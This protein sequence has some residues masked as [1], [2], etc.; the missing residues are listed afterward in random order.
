VDIAFCPDPSS[1]YGPR[2]QTNIE[3]GPLSEPLC[4]ASRPGHF[5][6][7]AT[8]VAKLFNLT[9][10]HVAIFGQKDFQQ[11][12][13]IRQM[14]VDLDFGIE[15]VGAPI[16]REPDGLAMSSRNAYLSSEERAQVTCLHRGLV[17]ARAAFAAGERDTAALLAA[18]RA[19]I[20]AA[21]LARID[22]VEL[23]DAAS[24]EM[25]DV[26]ERP[27]VLAMA[28]HF[29]RARLLDNTVLTPPE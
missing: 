25:I 26:V 4:G 18:A 16:V 10:P 17:A 6:G 28:V 13:V 5:R 20:E 14:V 3:V 8:V 21:P 1:M 12:A 11:L 19:P 9:M 7:V 15:I 23:R 22:Y 27:A 29:G 24:L 2:H